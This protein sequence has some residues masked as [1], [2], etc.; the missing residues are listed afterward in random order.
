A[1]IAPGAL[2]P[3]AADSHP[4]S[5][6]TTTNNE[7]KFFYNGIP[8]GTMTVSLSAPKYRSLTLYN[9]DASRL[10][11]IA[12]SERN[13]APRR[14]VKGNVTSATGQP[15][16]GA[17]VSPI[18]RP[19][20]GFPTLIT[21]DDK[22]QF[23]LDEVTAIPKGFAAIAQDPK[24]QISAFSV[25]RA[26][27]TK[28]EEKSWFD[29]L[30]RANSTDTKPDA[31]V[32]LVTRAVTE[33]V[34]IVADID[35]TDDVTGYTAKDAAVLMTMSDKGDEALIVRDRVIGNRLRYN[36]PVL[37]GGAS[38][39]LRVRAVGPNDTS[40]YH[41][42]YGLHGGE[43]ETKIGFL[44]APN[45][46]KGV[47]LKSDEGPTFSWDAVV[48]ADAYRVQLDK[49]DGET[50]WQ[51]WTTKTELTYPTS[52]GFEKLRDKDSYV[53]SVSA[54]KGLKS[55]GKIEAS[56]IDDAQW[57]DLAM[58]GNIDVDFS[59][60]AAAGRK[61]PASKPIVLQTQPTKPG[62]NPAAKPG[63]S[64]KPSGKPSGKPAAPNGSDS[65]SDSKTVSQPSPKPEETLESLDDVIPD[66]PKPSGS[67]KPSPKP[68]TTSI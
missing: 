53:W 58:T 35:K 52:K 59:G 47:F 62:N 42:V 8:E 36:M 38:Y 65:K 25:L 5:F 1:P 10:D 12:L 31:P 26:G 40:S 33:T 50:L 2:P 46:A 44:T 57:T 56:A 19:G 23:L 63:A 27:D 43:K 22:G 49:A 60:L 11:G 67:V 68:S 34:E 6:V 48:G 61:K 29:R 24:G 9:V 15:L 54:V 32:K 21:S 51:G 18:F 45:S 16:A 64:P 20:Q 37:P 3:A 39:H 30:F 17:L 66:A 28:T 41:H 14:S 13:E 55:G 7:G 4:E